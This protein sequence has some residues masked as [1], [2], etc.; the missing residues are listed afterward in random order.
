M[1]WIH[2]VVALSIG[3]FV[4]FIVVAIFRFVR[5]RANARQGCPPP[6]LSSRPIVTLTANHVLLKSDWSLDK[7][8][9]LALAILTKRACV[10][11]LVFVHDA[12]EEAERRPIVAREFH[13]I[14]D[15]SQILFCQTAIGR[16]AM[17]Q[18][19]ESV[20]HFDFD[21]DVI[22]EMAP[23][24]K[25]VIISDCEGNGKRA[26]WAAPTFKEFMTNGN[27]DFFKLLHT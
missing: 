21:P 26:D 10:F 5:R 17:A 25:T 27:T 12:D 15:E 2:G 24:R 22:S 6:V 13:G 9:R 3:L 4:I 8:A 19:L 18:Q 14:V 16:V 7:K 11:V 1:N 23:S 20:V